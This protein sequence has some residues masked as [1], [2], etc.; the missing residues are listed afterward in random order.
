MVRKMTETKDEIREVNQVMDVYELEIESSIKE[1]GKV[2]RIILKTNIGSISYR[3][4]KFEFENTY[5]DG[6]KVKQRKKARLMMSELSPMLWKL[7]KKLQK[8]ICKIKLRYFC[9]KKEGR[10]KPILFVR[11]KQIEE[12]EFKEM[13]EKIK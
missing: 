4:Y 8:G 1:P 13:E 7:N 12:M 9:W 6:N 2:H 11:E 3:P 5:V 10:E